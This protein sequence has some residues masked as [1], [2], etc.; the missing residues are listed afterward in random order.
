VAVEIGHED[1]IEI[2]VA[3]ETPIPHLFGNAEP[4]AEFHGARADLQ[5]FRRCDFVDPPLDEDGVNAAP[6]EVRGEGKA[7]RAASDDED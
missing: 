2:V 6:P 7:D 1:G 4:A 3:R 5:H